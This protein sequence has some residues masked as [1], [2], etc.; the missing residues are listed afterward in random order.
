MYMY[1]PWL[2]QYLYEKII[3]LS[4][5]EC[6]FLNTKQGCKRLNQVSHILYKTLVPGSEIEYIMVMCCSRIPNQD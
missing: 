6:D 5:L 4:D 3:L 1:I 2:Y